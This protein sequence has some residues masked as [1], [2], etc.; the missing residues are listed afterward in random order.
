MGPQKGH[1]DDEEASPRPANPHQTMSSEASWGEL[2][3]PEEEKA[4][5]E[6]QL[7]LEFVLVNCFEF[8]EETYS[9]KAV[10]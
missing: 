5:W 8:L 7:P 9:G 4:L 6:P 2:S 3:E 10:V 1:R